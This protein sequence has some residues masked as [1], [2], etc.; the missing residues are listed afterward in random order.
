M[1]TSL[2]VVAA[3][4]KRDLGVH[5]VFGDRG[6]YGWEDER[7]GKPDEGLAEIGVG[8]SRVADCGK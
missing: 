3:E 6:E 4:L 5:G 7:E 2:R 1:R 8:R